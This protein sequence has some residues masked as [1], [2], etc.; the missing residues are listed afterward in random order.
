MKAKS[1]L[2]IL[3][4]A[5]LLERRGKAFYTNAAA[6]TSSE[7]AK[8]IFTMMAEEEE[9][10]IN[11]LSDQFTNFSLNKYFKANVAPE[12]NTDDEIA[13][14]VLS[15]NVVKQIT[16]AS[17]EAAAISAAI[18]FET[19]AINVYTE[20]VAVATDVNEKEMYTMLA[21]W[22]KT[23]HL[24]L[25]QIDEILKESIWYDHRFWAF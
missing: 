7:A 8:K 3:K 12:N 5:I 20:S 16:A 10:H 19:R 9:E 21:N 6:N 14:K 4:E 11:F 22:E 15:A 23:H 1:T 18:D 13:R 2:D 17:Y 24:W 25:H